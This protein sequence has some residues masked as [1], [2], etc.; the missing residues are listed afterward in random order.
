VN[1][2]VIVVLAALLCQAAPGQ[3][4]ENKEAQV[5]EA[6]GIPP[7][8]TP[9]DYQSHAE[10][11]AV[12]IAAEFMGHSVPTPQATFSTEDYVV[13]EVGFFGPPE[14]RTKVSYE[15]FALR[16]NGK[17]APSP[18]QPYALV[19]SSL[20]D[21]EWAPPAPAEQKSKTSVGGGGGGGGRGPGEPPPAPVHMPFELQRA[22]EQRVQKAAVPEGE[23]ALPVA[24]LIFFQY[25]GKAQ[26]IHSIEL[27]YTGP[28]G[29]A[30]VALQP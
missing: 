17:K 5:R 12:T 10:A 11:G 24:G 6:K 9:G 28:A 20:K 16:I 19:L 1:C 18:A 13:V 22:M 4:T 8:A 2:S 26:G 25:R 30:T 3:E 21:P 29:K 15:D 23:R 7:R 14:A 27:M